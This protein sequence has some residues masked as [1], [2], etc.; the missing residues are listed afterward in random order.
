MYLVLELAPGGELFGESLRRTIESREYG[1]VDTDV[2]RMA[3]QAH[4]V[5]R[6]KGSASDTGGDPNAPA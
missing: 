3:Y 1:W 5:K 6:G 4:V 2:V